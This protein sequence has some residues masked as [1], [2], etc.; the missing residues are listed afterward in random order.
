M[1]PRSLVKWSLI[2]NF[3]GSF[4]V[5]NNPPAF[6]SVIRVRL[7]CLCSL[8]SLLIKLLVHQKKKNGLNG[9]DPINWTG[10][11]NKYI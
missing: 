10:P 6:V 1:V 3:F 11:K 5:G 2:C 9:L 4:D 7:V 8:F